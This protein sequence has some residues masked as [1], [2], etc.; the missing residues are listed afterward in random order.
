MESFDFSKEYEKC[1][2]LCSIFLDY[3][4]S[5]WVTNWYRF[6]ERLPSAYDDVH[7]FT[8]SECSKLVME[9]L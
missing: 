4:L 5:S 1:F 6:I 3:M 8:S 9:E 2:V 7:F